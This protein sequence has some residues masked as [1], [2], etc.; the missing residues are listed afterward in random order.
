M[1]KYENPEEQSI[2]DFW[3]WSSVRLYLYLSSILIM[4]INEIAALFLHTRLKIVFWNQTTLKSDKPVSQ[5][6]NLK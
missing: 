2:N 5:K 3:N 6:R 4:I 1:S